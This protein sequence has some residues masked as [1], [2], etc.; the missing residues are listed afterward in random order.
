VSGVPAV[1]QVLK[2]AGTALEVEPGVWVQQ[3]P[4]LRGAYLHVLAGLASFADPDGTNARP[5]VRSLALRSGVSE[6]TVTRTLALLE[7]DGEIVA[8][9]RR[10]RGATTNWMIAMCQPCSDAMAEPDVATTDPVA[11]IHPSS[12]TVSEPPDALSRSVTVSNGL[13]QSSDMVSSVQTP[14]PL[15][16]D[17]TPHNHPK[18]THEDH[19]E[20]TSSLSNGFPS[21]QA[22]GA[23]PEWLEEVRARI[24]D[25][26][27]E[28]DADLALGCF[29]SGGVVGARRELAR[30]QLIA[31]GRAHGQTAYR[32]A[33]A[34]DD[35]DL[36]DLLGIPEA[37]A[38][39]AEVEA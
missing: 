25:E 32:E 13:S 2:R 5:S 12:D 11:E 24:A 35:V 17:T 26:Y 6:R 36:P 31:N 19:L 21:E 29:Q 33:Q 14:R 23:T 34:F 38:A 28:L 15:R 8:Y 10:R 39:A 16:S 22:D 3:E 1:C 4:K 30:Q 27:P 37:P 7:A 18:T 20:K 9:S